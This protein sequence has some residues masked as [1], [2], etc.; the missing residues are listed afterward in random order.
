MSKSRALGIIANPSMVTVCREVAL[1]HEE[2]QRTLSEVKKRA[3]C[4]SCNT[5][6]PEFDGIRE[7]SFNL[8]KNLPDSDLR[9]LKILLMEDVLSFYVGEPPN[10]KK[11]TR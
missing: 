11:I 10:I 2:Y 3:G 6:N 7:K 1:L 4:A 8:I 9:R 5:A